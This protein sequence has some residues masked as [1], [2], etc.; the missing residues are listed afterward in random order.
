MFCPRL[1]DVGRPSGGPVSLHPEDPISGPRAARAPGPAARAR[2]SS[3][4][5]SSSRAARAGP[6]CSS[7]EQPQIPAQLVARVVAH[8][9]AQAR[10][11]LARP[12]ACAGTARDRAGRASRGT[13]AGG[14]RRARPASPRRP[15]SPIGPGLPRR[16]R[17]S[18]AGPASRP[19]TLDLRGHAEEVADDGA[20]P[21]GVARLRG[22]S[23]PRRTASRRRGSRRGCAAPACPAHRARRRRREAVGLGAIVAGGRLGAGP[24]AVEEH[25]QPVVE[26]VEEP[27]HRRSP[28]LRRRSRAYSV[29]CSGS[30]PFGPS[31]PKKLTLSRGGRPP[32]PAEAVQR[33]AARMPAT[34]PGPAASARRRDARPRRSAAGRASHV[35]LSSRRRTWKKSNCSGA[36]SSISN[37]S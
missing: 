12:A 13:C 21:V 27:R 25:Q 31:R 17:C 6:L 22:R 19:R 4:G 23:A 15:S 11:A 24:G 28:A 3:P 33:R 34:G 14:P 26:D 18:P 30:G 10:Q 20:Q 5:A 2:R 8:E 29:R 16:Q 9:R 32:R 37:S 35:M 36:R 1:R 7:Q